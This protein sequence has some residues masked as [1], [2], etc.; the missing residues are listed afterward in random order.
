MHLNN[1]EINETEKKDFENRLMK[2]AE[3][4][5]IYEEEP[6]KQPEEMEE[7]ETEGKKLT[8]KDI[9]GDDTSEESEASSTDT[10]SES[11]HETK[12][13]SSSSSNSS[14]ESD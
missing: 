3:P 6:E 8:E 13:K 1:D 4:E 12:K 9:F 7:Q 2:L 11:E 10:D 5:I 14:V